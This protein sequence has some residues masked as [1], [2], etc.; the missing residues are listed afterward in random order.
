MALADTFDHVADDD[1]RELEDRQ[2][3]GAVYTPGDLAAWVAA[4]MT[5]FSQ[6]TKMRIVDFGCGEGALL[7]A[8]EVM[9]PEH[10]LIGVET[11]DIAV[12]AATTRL[13]SQ[14]KIIKSDVLSP[15]AAHSNLAEYWRKRI[16]EPISGVVMNPPWGANPTISR[17]QAK[18][19]GLTL[20]TGQYDTYDLFCELALQVLDTG[21]VYGFILPD[22]VFLPEHENLRRL[23]TK[24]TTI[25]LIA[26]LG[27]G[28]FPSVYRGCV[29]VVGQNS[30]P[31][32]AAQVE[33]LRITKSE[34][35]RLGSS[36]SFEEARLQLGHR[37]PQVRFFNDEHCRFDIDVSQEDLTVF[38]MKECG[39][40]WTKFL[41]SARGAEISKHGKV[42]TCECGFSHPLP[43][44]E[45][46]LCK[47]CGKALDTTS[48]ENITTRAKP[49]G[50]DWLPFIVG[51]DVERYS[52]SPS[53]WIKR[54]V[55]GIKY[56]PLPGRGV[57]RLLIRKTGVGINA[58]IDLS[59]ALTNQVVFD[60]V[61]RKG[62][63]FDFSYLHYVLGVLSSRAMFAYHLKRGGE[64]EWRSHPYLTQKTI[65]Q[66]P[67]PVPTKGHWSWRQASAIAEAVEQHLRIGEGDL[68]IE[69]LVAGLFKFEES[70]LSWM[71]STIGSAADLQPM[72]LLRV[73]DSAKLRIVKVK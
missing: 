32:E 43:K 38:K 53:R 16:E 45:A 42:L 25:K 6:S 12:R 69:G 1:V 63:E 50:P 18:Y 54:D 31:N 22:S 67:V 47:S 30:V 62:K 34:R 24:N 61:V 21:G 39:A 14:S 52:V 65:A 17:K 33:C 23:I 37:V 8:F 57:A 26:R 13:P 27:E 4:L 5:G 68:Q 71:A 7:K 49:Q 60:Y 15:L 51:E 55:S 44:A 64:I 20:A 28:V 36:L 10:E 66:L 46:P 40:D 11:N 41:H 58:G 48:I 29:V 70:D 9:P 2:R 35:M 73:Q 19:V 72:R 59:Q 56:K 3:L